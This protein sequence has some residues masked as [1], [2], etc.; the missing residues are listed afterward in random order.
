MIN[1]IK[2]YLREVDEAGGFIAKVKAD[3]KP[4][5][6]GLIVIVLLAGSAAIFAQSARIDNLPGQ[7]IVITAVEF[8]AA[9][10][11]ECP[12]G[13]YYFDP[14]D[15][16][17]DGKIETCSEIPYEVCSGSGAAIAITRHIMSGSSCINRTC[18]PNFSPIQPGCE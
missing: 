18:G 17:K 12:S 2:Q 10:I 3:P 4:F 16:N 13:A 6:I 7:G 8:I 9:P 5:I 11:I 15:I 1:S 14:G